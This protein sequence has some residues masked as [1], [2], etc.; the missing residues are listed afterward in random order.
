MGHSIRFSIAV[1]VWEDQVTIL[2]G[3]DSQIMKNLKSQE[4][5]DYLEEDT[6][7]VGIRLSSLNY[8]EEDLASN[9]DKV[10]RLKTK[11]WQIKLKRNTIISK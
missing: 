9:S 1:I 4:F 5:Y 11:G 7:E 3:A 6:R 10:Q 2:H 8:L